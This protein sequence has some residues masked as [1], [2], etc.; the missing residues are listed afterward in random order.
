MQ[1][2]VRIARGEFSWSEEGPPVLSDM[3]IEAL[4]GQLLM[5]V[6]EVGSGKSSLLSTILGEM[7][8]RAG[9]VSVRGER[10]Q[11]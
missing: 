11:L 3:N 7:H 6:G 4:E 9:E 8:K 5:I 10:V 1:P 2:A